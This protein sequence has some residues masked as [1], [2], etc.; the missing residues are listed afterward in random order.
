MKNS[1]DSLIDIYRCENEVFPKSR[2][3]QI[4]ISSFTSKNYKESTIDSA[5]KFALE[6]R[7]IIDSM[8]LNKIDTKN[9]VKPVH[10]PM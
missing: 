1:K 6:L 7:N 2:F 10:I 8:C 9:K 4:Y 3:M 5:K